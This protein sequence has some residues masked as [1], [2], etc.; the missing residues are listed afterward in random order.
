MDL[1]ITFLINKVQG[2]QTYQKKVQGEQH[3]K[4]QLKLY[5]K[6][7]KDDADTT[8]KYHWLNLLPQPKDPH[9]D[10][11]CGECG[12]LSVFLDIPCF[13][14]AYLHSIYEMIQFF[15]VLC[16]KKLKAKLFQQQKKKKTFL[17]NLFLK[18]KD[19]KKAKV[20]DKQTWSVYT[21]KK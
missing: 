13:M 20:F 17:L 3:P 19:K 9:I 16:N 2:E 11:L 6:Y 4:Y 5:R 15:V 18:S 7:M 21:P 1:P 14:K 8:Q 10:F 12:G